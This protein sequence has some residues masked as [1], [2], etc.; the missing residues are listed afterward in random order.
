MIWKCIARD[1]SLAELFAIMMSL[2]FKYEFV[3][4]RWC[5]ATDLMLKK[6][7]GVRKIHQ[8]RIIGLLED[9]FNTALKLIFARK[10][11]RNSE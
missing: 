7:P 3:N 1:E 5:K 10:M 4:E 6:K 8:L 9:D 11:M 2:Q